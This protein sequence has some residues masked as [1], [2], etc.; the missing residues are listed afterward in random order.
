MSEIR[1]LTPLEYLQVQARKNRPKVEKPPMIDPDA[2]CFAYDKPKAAFFT[3]EKA[4]AA[5]VRTQERRAAD[6]SPRTEKRFYRCERD[7]SRSRLD[8]EHFHLTSMPLNEFEQETRDV[9]QD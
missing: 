1:A 5:L 3:E 6:G 9:S 4:S 8:Q 2:L 7:P